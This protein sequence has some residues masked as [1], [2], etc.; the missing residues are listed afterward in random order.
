M[1]SRRIATSVIMCTMAAALLAPGS[2]RGAEEP[3][4]AAEC[5]PVDP[6]QVVIGEVTC[7]R[8][9]SGALGG[10]TAFTYYVP[11]ACGP[12]S[13]CP[14][15]Y[16][17]S[18][19]GFDYREMV[20]TTAAPS[21]WVHALTSGPPVD[22]SRVADPWN[23]ADPAGWIPLDPIDLILVAPHDRTVAG[24]YGPAEGMEGYWV[25]W[26]PRYAGDGDSER[27]PTPPPRFQTHIVDELL[28]W[29][30]TNLPALSGRAGRAI[31]GTDTGGFGSYL[32]G[33]QRP[34]LWSGVGSV[35][36]AP[37]II[38]VPGL[39]PAAGGEALAGIPRPD[40]PYMPTPSRPAA[41][42][43][44]LL[45][46]HP[47]NSASIALGDPVS[48]QAYIR[49]N[50]PRH[51]VMNA[52]ASAGGQPSVYLRATVGDA[53]PRRVEDAADPVELAVA[54]AVEVILLA[55]N[56]S[57]EAA[58]RSEGVPHEFEIHPGIN[59]K[60]Y[61]NPFLRAHLAALYERV[62]HRDGAGAPPPSPASFDFRS[63]ARSFGVWGWTFD[64]HREA[65][66][67]LNLQSV[68]CGGLTLQGTGL[69]TVSVPQACGTGLDG[70]R[71]F[72]VD[73]G[74]GSPA[75]EYAGASAL[76]VYSTRV[77]LVLSPLS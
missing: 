30:E 68:S 3:A 71:A 69:V 76:P 34:D 5:L 1:R 62:Q 59:A 26:N 73:L 66:E 29:V 75:D 17:L 13:R 2:S 46:T 49:G 11:P 15:L 33:L 40:L 28:P 38:P 39:A 55:N 52:L 23:Y 22:P 12:E 51:L 19:L 43:S 8:F 61:R 35:S 42:D 53:V 10:V 58:L 6:P 31:S 54:Q 9:A 21:A 57:M 60:V 36:G 18:G 47:Y 64:V 16:L 27:Y 65:T 44:I 45:G 70:E 72:T 74:P 56:L 63:I 32:L 25:D 24:G 67:F 37:D 7:R 14:T 77:S 20:G 4:F 50:M 41:V 48:D